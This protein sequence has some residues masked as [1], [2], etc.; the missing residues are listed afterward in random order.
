MKKVLLVFGF[1]LA[2]TFSTNAQ[3]FSD[4]AIGLKFGSISTFK[5]L[6]VTYQRKI[7][8]KS[9]LE[10]DVFSDFDNVSFLVII[11]EFGS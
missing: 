8:T 5:Y 7:T 4:N 6:N 2:A 11:K 9:R 10:L 3:G 1:V